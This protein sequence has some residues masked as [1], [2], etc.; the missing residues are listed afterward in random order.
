M[1]ILGR[2]WVVMMVCCLFLSSCGREEKS[3]EEILGTLCEVAGE[4]PDG[5]IYR[6]SAEEGEDGY[7]SAELFGS[8]Y[9][10][11][12]KELFSSGILEDCAIYLSSFEAPYEIA[13]FRAYSRSDADSVA[14]LCL[15]RAD[16]LQ[17]ALHRTEWESL[18]SSAHVVV[19]GRWVVFLV[20]DNQEE[21]EARALRLLR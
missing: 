5:E 3:A 6:L 11:D 17:V 14:A 15:T 9:G 19:R 16:E 12:G 4:L 13:V 10:E 20:T 18:A 7:L 8:L 1:R 2:V 21:A